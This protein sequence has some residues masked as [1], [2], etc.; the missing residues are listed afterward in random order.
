MK[1]TISLFMLLASFGI[2]EIQAQ[3]A[4]VK[5]PDGTVQSIKN[6][7][8][9]S[10]R[11]GSGS[12]VLG[13]SYYRSNAGLN[14]VQAS[15]L[16]ETRASFNLGSGFPATLTIS[17][18]PSGAIIDTA[19]VYMAAS[20]WQA[21]PPPLAII[22]TNP[23]SVV[24]SFRC[25]NI[26]S[27]TAV[28][29]GDKGTAAYRTGIDNLISGNGNYT[30]NIKGIS[31][32]SADK[33]ID[34][35]TLFIVYT[36]PAV[37]DTGTVVLADGC[38]SDIH[39][40]GINYTFGGF[41]G[42]ATGSSGGQGFVIAADIQSNVNPNFASAYNGRNYTFASNFWNFAS[43]NVVL[44]ASQSFINYDTYT[45]NTGDCFLICMEGIYFQPCGSGD[46]IAV[47]S[48]DGCN[49]VSPPICYVSVD[50]LSQHDEVFWDK[51]SLDTMAIDSFIIYRGVTMSLYVP[52]GRVAANAYSSFVDVTSNPNATS[53]FYKLGVIDT[54]HN[55][56]MPSAYNQSVFLQSSLGLGN[57]VN[58]SWND[59]QGEPVS[60]YRILR[61]DS[62][63]GNWH[64]LDS[65]PGLN[66]AY[67][68][69]S[70]PINPGLRYVLNTIWNISCRPSARVVRG[71]GRYILPLADESYSN[72]VSSSSTG[73]PYYNPLGSV[74][75]YPNPVKNTIYVNLHSPLDGAISISN[76]LGQQV[77]S[78]MISASK[79]TEEIDMSLYPNGVYF[80]TIESDGQ[81]VVKK[82]VK[83]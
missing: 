33:E 63:H 52:V 68:D 28:C 3:Q 34:G 21:S 51:S 16:T 14:Y 48:H 15:V 12:H 27:D 78:K 74:E 62:G 41:T 75:V 58:L 31:T 55:N 37:P 7:K 69:N 29:W 25:V 66:T 65:V 79:L 83:L 61:D 42:C 10:G 57:K 60:Y 70:P 54:C 43:G 19:F 49:M 80:L 44:P 4:V 8:Q 40:T 39:G 32:S 45:N 1:K 72:N 67:T 50:T 73:T 18:L 59:Y 22:V 2:F 11:V 36:N 46:T 6:Y 24:D 30:I 26:G 71:H 77:Y 20:Y 9:T 23:V 56:H 53:Y 81:R 17:G 38:L 47:S 82:I 64:V 5:K 35:V 13:N 76:V